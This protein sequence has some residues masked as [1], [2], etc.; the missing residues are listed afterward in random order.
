MNLFENTI[1]HIY[2]YFKIN[3]LHLYPKSQNKLYKEL[4]NCSRALIYYTPIKYLQKL[5]NTI[6]S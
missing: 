5:I 2:T 1:I 6:L 4:L 3:C